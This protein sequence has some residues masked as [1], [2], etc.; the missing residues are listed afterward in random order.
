M[1]GY[2]C[3]AHVFKLHPPLYLPWLSLRFKGASTG[4]VVDSQED[5]PAEEV[6]IGSESGLWIFD[7]GIQGSWDLERSVSIGVQ[8]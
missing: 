5:G 6:C 7:Q 3:S 1:H 4:S 2:G 8:A